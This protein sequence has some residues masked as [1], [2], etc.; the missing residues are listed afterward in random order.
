[1]KKYL[2]LLPFLSSSLL[3]ADVE[4]LEKRIQELEEIVKELKREHKVQLNDTINDLARVVEKV[5]TKTLA[6]K[7]NWAPEVR[8]RTDFFHYKN[9]GI[10]GETTSNNG[11]QLRDEFTKNYN[12]A[13]SVRLRLNMTSIL[14]DH[15]RFIGRFSIHRNS[16]SSERVCILS[17]T[18]MPSSSTRGGF[19]IDKAY[20]DYSSTHNPW[21]ISFGILP[22]SGGSPTHVQE[23]T[24]RKSVFPALIFDANSY[25]IMATYQGLGYEDTYIR[26]LL[27]KMYT[28]DA[29]AFYYQCNREIIKN[30]DIYGLFYEGKKYGI[31]FHSGIVRIANIQ[32]LPYLGPVIESQTTP[33]NLGDIDLIG[34][35]FMAK[36]FFSQWSF[37]GDLGI[38]IPHGNGNQDSYKGDV[39]EVTNHTAFTTADYAQGTL[40]QK[41]GV[42]FHLGTHYTLNQELSI[43]LEYNQG[44]RYW[45][46][47]TQGS[48]DV[49]NKYAT[50]GSVWDSY[51]IY[52]ISKNIFAKMGLTYTKEKWTGSGWHFATP[53]QKN[54]EQTNGYVVLNAAF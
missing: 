30:G 29:D 1:M 43:G 6:D 49:F 9:N 20:I 42:A 48:E 17:N 31:D 18:V 2:F 36:N 25:G 26:G 27:G 4:T 23:N 50:R 15:I 3:C 33:N 38:S 37:F 22:T 46:S 34:L 35:G 7:I 10:E 41:K 39:A 51:M 32:A 44:S 52:N 16:Q 19:D 40:L 14:N 47:A 12:P 21:I 28:Q 24:P 54:A 45:W 5:E 13:L 53:S 11:E 8:L